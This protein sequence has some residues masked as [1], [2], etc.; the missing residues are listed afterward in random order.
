M[1]AQFSTSN[2]GPAARAARLA[3]SLTRP[4]VDLRGLLA[5]DVVSQGPRPL[6]VAF[7]VAGGHEATRSRPDVPPEPFAPEAIW[8]YCSERG[9]TGNDGMLLTDAA[10][11]VSDLGQPPLDHWP[12]NPALGSGTEP[13]PPTAGAPPWSTAT[14]RQLRLAHDGVEDRVEDELAA[15]APVILL[16][17]VTEQFAVPNDD[18]HVELPDLRAQPGGYHA[19]LCV[20][21]ATD[22]LRGRRLLIRNSWGEYWGLGG[23]CWL[24]MA[25][26]VAFVPQAAVVE[27]G[28]R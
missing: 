4:D 27:L 5:P 18:G 23:Y 26:L 3:A 10:T 6:C 28:V 17:E 24:P 21:A 13:P 15:G 2:R 20:G 9:Q 7:A 14:I 8:W 12:Y 1:T 19:V 11:A 16:V 22:P 25:Y